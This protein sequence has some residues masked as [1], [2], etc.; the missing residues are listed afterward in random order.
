[1]GLIHRDLKPQHVILSSGG[2]PVLVDFALAWEGDDQ[3]FSRLTAK[4]GTRLYMS[5]EQLLPDRKPVDH[6]S[7]LF[8]AG[9]LLYEMLTLEHPFRA[10]TD[11][12]TESNILRAA[13]RPLR[14]RERRLPRDLEAVVGKALDRDPARRYQLGSEF[15]ADLRRFLAGKSVEARPLGPAGRTVRW[16]ARNPGRTA[17]AA[18]ALAAL[19]VGTFHVLSWDDQKAKEAITRR[20]MDSFW[21]EINSPDLSIGDPNDVFRQIPPA[22]QDLRRGNYLPLRHQ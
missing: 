15:A 21:R 22:V 18:L 20:S 8:T 11:F 16:I 3:S 12:E 10:W 9:V 19:S 2:T 1:M 13:P 14:S 17:A 6:R 7:D 4:F 5:P